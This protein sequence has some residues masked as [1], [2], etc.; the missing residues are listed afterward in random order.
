[1][2]K[3]DILRRFRYALDLSDSTMIEI[4]SLGGRTVKK[5]ELSCLLKKEDDPDYVECS[6][7]VMTAFLDGLI[8]HKR[9]TREGSEEQQ[10]KL[11][12]A[13]NNNLILKKMRIALELNEEGMLAIM[14][15]AGV[16][17]SKS[18]LSALFRRKEHKNFKECGD[19]F[20][21]NFLNGLTRCYR[22]ASF[23]DK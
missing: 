9:G 22:E 11:E 12:S 13:L 21:R 8:I 5:Y 18:E 6:D 7:E 16:I 1:M 15:L 4:F 23:T 14:K 20:L 2:T 3:N 10:E 19:Q 17:V